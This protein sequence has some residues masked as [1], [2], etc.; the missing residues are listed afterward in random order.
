MDIFSF[1][2]NIED[3]SPDKKKR[4]E[5]FIALFEKLKNY[6]NA[7]FNPISGENIT[8]F[9][10]ALAKTS[11]LLTEITTKAIEM[12]GA[13]NSGGLDGVAKMVGE[14]NAK[15]KTAQAETTKLTTQ[16]KEQQKELNKLKV[17]LS[18]L[19]TELSRAKIQNAELIAE[20]MK[21]SN[22][23]KA[24]AKDAE[25]LKNKLRE[26]SDEYR[27]LYITQGKNS[28]QTKTAL[29]NYQVV[30]GT[31]NN[32]NTNLRE[33]TVSGGKTGKALN[34]VFGQ[35]RTIAY[36]LPGL[37]IAGIFNIAFEAIGNAM[38]E[39][40]SFNISLKEQTILQTSLNSKILE[41]LNLYEGILKIKREFNENY[42]NAFPG[43]A[44][45]GLDIPIKRKEDAAD[46]M[47][48]RG[49]DRGT[50]LRK[51]VENAQERFNIAN[52]RA[53]GGILQETGN[54]QSLLFSITQTEDKI[55]S[56]VDE[57][58]KD[59]IATA[60]KRFGKDLKDDDLSK[61]GKN[62]DF[63]EQVDTVTSLYKTELDIFKS[64]YERSKAILEEYYSS[65]KDLKKKMAELSKFNED[66]NRKTDVET[67]KQD[68]SKKISDYQSDF[69][70]FVSG[71]FA[72]RQSLSGI[73]D[74]KKSIAQSELDNIINNLSSTPSDI[75]VAKNKHKN[76]LDIID[77]EYDKS[78]IK[79]TEEYSQRRLTA[80]TQID[81]NEIEA[82]ARKNE[83]IFRNDELDLD[84]RLQAYNNYLVLK[85]SLQNIE[86]DK[87]IQATSLKAVNDP[88]VIRE[89]ERL[90]SDRNLQLRS[91][92]SDAQSQVYDIITT[93]LDKRLNA[94]VKFN[95]EE[96]FVNDNS[97]ADE[98]NALRERNEKGLTI[99][100]DY[101]S[102]LKK[103]DFKYTVG[104]FK[105][106]I[107]DTEEDLA[108]LRKLLIEQQLL[109][110][111]AKVSSTL[112]GLTLDSV[113]LAGF[114]TLNAERNNEAAK[115]K[116]KG[117][118]DAVNKTSLQINLKEVELAK[119]NLGLAKYLAQ[120]ES[121][122]DK[123]KMQAR[124]DLLKAFYELAMQLNEDYL[125]SRI[126]ALEKEA[127]AQ[128]KVL[129]SE[130]D[131]VNDS[132]LT[133][134][135]KTALGIQLKEEEMQKEREV[136]AEEKS[137][138]RQKA[139]IDKELAIAYIVW[140][141]AQ[142]ISQAATLP[143]PADLIVATERAALGAT[144][145]AAVVTKDVPS[146]EKGTQG[147]AHK[148]GPARTG[149]GG[150]PEIIKEPYKSPYLVFKDNISYLPTGTEVIPLKDIPNFDV[151]TNDNSWEQFRW[152]AR[153]MK[154]GNREIK[155]T[156]NNEINIDLGM[157]NY[158]RK[159]L[160][161]S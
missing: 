152:L 43:A 59:W 38:S 67:N 112:T 132:S 14:Y 4:L 6:N 40:T 147:I 83:V 69:D 42:L 82:E 50:V 7:K 35:L 8:K 126:D 106:Q 22:A 71:E 56:V 128:K 12:T 55:K 34:A 143:P 68:Q 21:D 117:A 31:V 115:G 95:R 123:I 36:I 135:D 85:Q 76:D 127:E 119:Q 17:Q 65:D 39:L 159:I 118:G 148:G 140:N 10:T 52:G 156:I 145:L 92:Q 15:T 93:S 113:S 26:L 97:Y 13:F 41:Q 134:K 29:K 94:I 157:L 99:T 47:Q 75:A 16:V 109:L 80:N 155:N 23:T 28:D 86:F 78:L 62:K 116:E 74:S 79:L 88:T 103:L 104:G 60:K 61:L 110:S 51:E 66:E 37:G 33:T 139:I 98:L 121:D 101:Q 122:V 124:E 19:G 2:L 9:N 144:Q 114:D 25:M 138:K 72:K 120:Q 70:D 5:E 108:K 102:E 73:R 77:N 151:P 90:D 96:R 63:I 137:L 150:K 57:V 161:K 27:R 81:K 46:I 3:F 20:K 136:S 111:K 18:S 154:Q 100:K 130:I 105:E 87:D 146:Y 48:A 129:E 158:K 49:Y 141:T 53:P 131:A 149:E 91:I 125:K 89:V 160:G 24:L 11:S 153:Q 58:T 30:A 44:A 133:Q 45:I 54:A 1:G 142:G 107:S 32:I 64:E 84:K